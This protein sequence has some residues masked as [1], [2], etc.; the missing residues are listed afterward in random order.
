MKKTIGIVGMVAFCLTVNSTNAQTPETTQP[1]VAPV[2]QTSTWDHRKNPTVVAITSKYEGK[3]LT[4]RPAST[5]ADVFPV[6]GKYESSTNTDAPEVTIVL[7][8][9]NKGIAWIEGLPQ[10]RIKAMLRKSPATYKI[11]AQKTEDGKEVAEGTLIFDKET[12]TLSISIGKPFNAE[13]P[14]SVFAAPVV[15]EPAPATTKSSKSKKT[16]TVQQPKAWIYTGT[17]VIVETPVAT[18]TQEQK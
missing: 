13:D 4:A 2:H 17:K 8:A 9:E 6:I 12:N 14:A 10:G 18:T 1:V 15:E 7:D 3:Y 16:K 11:P 5:E